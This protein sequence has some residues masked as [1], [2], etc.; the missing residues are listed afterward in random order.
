MFNLAYDIFMNNNRDKLSELDNIENEADTIKQ[1]L[2]DSHYDR[3]TKN[4][5][6]IELSP[7]FTTVVSDLERVADHL[8]NV[9]YARINPTG[10][11]IVDTIPQK[12]RKSGAKKAK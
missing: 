7:V 4:I 10:D 8:V 11:V 1:S 3:I 6:T 12:N 9:G 2:N 5:C